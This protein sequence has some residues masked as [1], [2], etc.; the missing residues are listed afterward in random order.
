MPMSSWSCLSSTYLL[1]NYTK[2]ALNT[3]SL[4]RPIGERKASLHK[5]KGKQSRK[6]KL[7]HG[8]QETDSKGSSLQAKEAI[9]EPPILPHVLVGFNSVNRHLEALSAVS[10]HASN[11]LPADA[12][13]GLDGKPGHIATVFL[14]RPPDELIY[15]HLP[16]VCFTSSLAH[17]ELPGTRLMLLDTDAEEQI[18]EALRYARVSMLALTKPENAEGV[19]GMAALLDYVREHVNAVEVGWLSDAVEGKWLGTKIDVH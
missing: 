2:A 17:P 4:L 19:P 11:P 9:S 16:T 8:G 1:L 12:A 18:A 10:G 3:R 15:R 5:S 14:L 6:R 13:N 7:G